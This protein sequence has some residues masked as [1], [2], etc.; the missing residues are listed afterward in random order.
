LTEI[1]DRKIGILRGAY[2]ARREM[3]NL[4]LIL[5]A[6]GSELSLA[7]EAA[8]DFSPFVRVVSMPSME[9]FKR[10]NDGY[11]EKILP[12]SC[13]LMLAVEAGIA[14]PWYAF[15]GSEGH[16]IAVDDFGF[17]APGKEVQEYFGFTVEAI[18]EKIRS[19]LA[20]SGK[21]IR[22]FFG[23]NLD[24]ELTPILQP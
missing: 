13:K 1:P 23:Q 8:R 16:V 9:V 11:K 4:Q 6:T 3:E 20:N 5:L 2:I 21:W 10:Q 17:S 7:L 12:K 15:V 19:L 22:N 24:A 14:M 18:R